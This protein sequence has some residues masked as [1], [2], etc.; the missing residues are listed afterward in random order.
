MELS[1]SI[2]GL[3]VEFKLPKLEARVR[4]PV[5]AYLSI[6]I[7]LCSL[8]KYIFGDYIRFSAFDNSILT[9]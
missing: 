3:V 5:D 2:Y 6:K 9:F 4:F 8:F 7:Y 1:P